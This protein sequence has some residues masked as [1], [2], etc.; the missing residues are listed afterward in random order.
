MTNIIDLE[1]QSSLQGHLSPN[2]KLLWV[3]RPKEGIIFRSSDIFLIPFSLLWCG[4]AIFW[5]TMVVTSGAPFFF[6][7][8]GIPFVLIGLYITVGRFFIDAL[9]RKNTIYGIT[10]NRIIIKSGIFSTEVKSLNIRTLS[11]ITFTEKS[12]GTGSILLGPSNIYDAWGGAGWP[13]TK[14]APR[15]EFIA[16]VRKVYDLLNQ[17]Q[18]QSNKQ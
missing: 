16:D 18:H 5:E 17:L 2:E 8:W 11:D 3:D 13:G 1:L 6:V 10:D 7:I 14:S 12:N 15:L 9:K 4:F